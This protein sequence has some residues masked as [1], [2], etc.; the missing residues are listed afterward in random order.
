M[1]A[2]H[3]GILGCLVLTFYGSVQSALARNAHRNR[4]D[5]IPYAN[6]P[7]WAV[8]FGRFRKPYHRWYVEPNTLGYDGAAR[9]VPD[10]ILTHLKTVN[11]GVLAPL[12]RNNPDSAYGIPM[13]HGAELAVERA[14]ARGG[15]DGIP[16]ALRVHDDLPLWGASWMAIVKMD[17]DQHV[18][19]MLG[20]VNSASTHI[21]LRATLKLEIPIIDTA[22]ND[23]TVTE[24]RIPWLLHNFPDDRQQGYA[25][26]DYIFNQ[27]KLRHVAVLRATNRYGRL[28]DA[29]FLNCARRLSHQPVLEAKYS[30]GEQSFSTQLRMLREQGIDGLV[31][32][33][34]AWEAGRILKQMRALGMKQPVFASSRVCSPQVIE[35]AGR[36]AE[37]L[38]TACAMNPDRT[39]PKWVRF[40]QAF[41]GQFHAEPDAYAA[42]AYDG[43]N[44][45]IG[46]I[47]KAGLNRGKIMDALRQYEMKG[48]RGVAGYAFF[49]YTLN[50]IAP[51][52]LGRVRN[53]HFIYWPERR[54]DWGGPVPSFMRAE[55]LQE[56]R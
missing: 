29:V 51:I 39:N 6:M 12:D 11:I 1:K 32:W 9:E 45:L 8:P 19:A 26:A 36:A 53:G 4:V 47:R 22:T 18:W 50:N 34:D 41:L 33:G 56:S 20:S 5:P 27:L 35:I 48:Y 13:L 21:E 28:G 46:A 37:G 38:V 2:I 17:Y 10:G 15:N 40:R 24:T 55:A 23:P 54:T 42:Y 43:M 3:Y 30:P 49:D 14:N 44:I 7:K 25:L 31:I 52:T 16:F